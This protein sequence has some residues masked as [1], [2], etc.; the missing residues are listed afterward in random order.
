MLLTEMLKQAK[1]V[2]DVAVAGYSSENTNTV[3]DLIRAA[4]GYALLKRRHD[5]LVHALANGQYVNVEGSSFAVKLADPPAG[6]NV[7]SLDVMVR[8]YEAD[9]QLGCNYL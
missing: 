5:L 9:Q 1:D 8:Q 6:F 2:L 3:L 7:D 4:R